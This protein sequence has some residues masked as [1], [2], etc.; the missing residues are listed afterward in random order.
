MIGTYK[1]DPFGTI[2]LREDGKFTASDWPEFNYPD[3]PKRTGGGSGT[4]ELTPENKVIETADDDIVL[5]FTDG[6]R[7]WDHNFDHWSEGFAFGVTGSRDK[8]RFYRFTTDPDVC[9]LHTL[10]RK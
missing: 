9:E 10:R 6:K 2:A 4:W 1:A 5:S 7:V 3:K 8:P